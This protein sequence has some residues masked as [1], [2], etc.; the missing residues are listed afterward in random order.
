MASINNLFALEQIEVDNSSVHIT[1]MFEEI[2][3]EI[4]EYWPEKLTLIQQTVSLT[5]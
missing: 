5:F 3:K 1:R 4:V 2:H